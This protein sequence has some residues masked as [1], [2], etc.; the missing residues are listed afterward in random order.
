MQRIEAITLAFSLM[1]AAFVAGC[2]SGRD[3][4]YSPANFT[5]E[6]SRQE[7]GYTHGY[8]HFVGSRDDASWQYN[9][10]HQQPGLGN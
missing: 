4:I 9:Q 3:H 8:D 7:G 2:A 6:T 5:G 10:D 1:L